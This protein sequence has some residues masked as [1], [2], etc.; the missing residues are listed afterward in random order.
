MNLLIQN[1]LL[2][3]IFLLPCTVGVSNSPYEWSLLFFQSTFTWIGCKQAGR[4]QVARTKSR[5]ADHYGIFKDL[6]PMAYFVPRV[7]YDQDS[8]AQVHYGNHLMPKE[9]SVAPQVSF[10][11]DPGKTLIHHLR[12]RVFEGECVHWLRAI[13]I[14]SLF[15]ERT[16][17][18]LAPIPAKATGFNHFVYIMFRQEG[19]INFHEDI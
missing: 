4:R 17:Q 1:I 18:Y 8:S 2:L 7:S 15:P 3:G 10:V 11:A 14:L 19:T 16:C 9:A 12:I 5:L 13:D 6:F